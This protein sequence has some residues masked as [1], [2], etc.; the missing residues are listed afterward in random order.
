[1]TQAFDEFEA[2]VI[3]VPDRPF[4]GTPSWPKREFP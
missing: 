2:A 4:H 3:E 1:M